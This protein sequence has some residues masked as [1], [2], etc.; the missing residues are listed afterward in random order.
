MVY[1]KS[2][3]KFFNNLL[4][5]I[6]ILFIKIYQY[7][8][9][10]DKWIPSFWLKWKVCVH[11]PHCSAYGLQVLQRYWFIPWIFYTMD[12]IS[13]CHPWNDNHY[14]P[15]VCRV[16]FMSSAPIW[17]SFLKLLFEDKRF[18][19]VWVVTNQDKQVWR[20][21]Q[22][23]ENSIKSLSKQLI[24]DYNLQVDEN[25]F[26]KTPAK[27]NP[28][29]SQ[30]WLEFFDWLK[31]RNIDYLIVIAYW[32]ILPKSILDIPLK[33]AINVHG[34]IL[35]LY[36]GASP[37]QSV[38]LDKAI[39]TWITIMNMNEKMDE[40]D[41][42]KI[43]KFDIKFDSTTKDIIDIM[44]Q[45]GPKFLLDCVW[46]HAKGHIQPVPQDHEQATYCKKFEK[47]DWQIDVFDEQ[48]QDIYAKYKAFFLWP[49]IFF[50][51]DKRFWKHFEKRVIIQDLQIDQIKIQEYWNLWLFDKDLNLNPA[52]IDLKLK[53]EWKSL[54]SYEDF[55]K[56]YFTH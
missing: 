21:L 36:R 26:I 35:P 11:R 56:W 37:I 16:V 48:L 32:K 19:L 4:A 6:L 41:I 15:A 39:Q 17:E 13:S 49:K 55:K 43:L 20:W 3:F 14:D 2:I 54:I 12:R 40:W 24:K 29:K 25:D 50:V 34:S 5:Q 9:S 46:Q 42:L 44:M 27:I 47:Q 51:L 1:I 10:P 38:L 31:S 45:K 30:E 18:E 7:T 22:M 53:P 33:S 28:D 8:L 23:Q 52:I